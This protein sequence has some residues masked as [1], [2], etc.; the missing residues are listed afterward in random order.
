MDRGV[1]RFH[2][3]C[4]ESEGPEQRIKRCGQH[5]NQRQLGDRCETCRGVGVISRI[6]SLGIGMRVG[7]SYPVDNV[8]VL[9]KSRPGQVPDKKYEQPTG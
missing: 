4:P 8:R 2:P 5:Q 1:A 7:D 9:K 6:G 3:G